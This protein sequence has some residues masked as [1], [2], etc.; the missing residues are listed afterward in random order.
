M[1]I[2]PRLS[3]W[4]CGPHFL[5]ALPHGRASDTTKTRVT[6]S[7]NRPRQIEKRN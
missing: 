2:Y 5:A 7:Q 3:A 1:K 6:A 4:I